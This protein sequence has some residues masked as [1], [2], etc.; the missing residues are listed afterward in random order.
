MSE[1]IQNVIS[2]QQ[3]LLCHK[4]ERNQN[5]AHKEREDHIALAFSFFS[6]Y[7]FMFRAHL[8]PNTF[9]HLKQLDHNVASFRST[10]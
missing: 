5:K 6:S 9:L 4:T 8:V 10:S 7:F 1:Q 2:W 3:T